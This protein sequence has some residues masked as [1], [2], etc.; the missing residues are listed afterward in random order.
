MSRYLFITLTLRFLGSVRSASIPCWLSMVTIN[1]LS[2]AYFSA[3]VCI[4]ALLTE[5]RAISEALKKAERN[6]RIIIAANNCGNA[7]NYHLPFRPWQNHPI[8][9]LNLRMNSTSLTRCGSASVTLIVQSL[10]VKI[11]PFCGKP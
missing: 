9:L 8:V 7:S 2:K 11:A 6:S 4:L 10:S 3:I 1:C 5:V